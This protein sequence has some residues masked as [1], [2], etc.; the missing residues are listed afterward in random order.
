MATVCGNGIA[1]QAPITCEHVHEKVF[2]CTECACALVCVCVC[3]CVW[4]GFMTQSSH[5]NTSMHQP[6]SGFLSLSPINSHRCGDHGIQLEPPLCKG[7]ACVCVCVCV[8]VRVCS[9]VCPGFYSDLENVSG[10]RI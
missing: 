4:G 6:L 5:N 9:C 2:V 10:S 8:C 3:L 7:T 1:S